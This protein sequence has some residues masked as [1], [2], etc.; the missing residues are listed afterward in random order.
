MS[1][2]HPECLPRERAA[3]TYS[4]KDD[5]AS[6]FDNESTLRSDPSVGMVR[7]GCP[8]HEGV[9]SRAIEHSESVSGPGMSIAHSRRTTARGR[10]EYL[11]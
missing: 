5:F 8:I 1:C 2:G 6:E 4:A 9:V 10:S 3:K 11:S 7:L